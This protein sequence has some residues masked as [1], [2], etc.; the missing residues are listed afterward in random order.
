MSFALELANPRAGWLDVTVA[1]GPRIAFSASHVLN[2]PLRELAEL[3]LF[4]A[5]RDRGRCAV[6]FWLE[7]EGHELA[8]DRDDTLRLTWR[9]ADRARPD[10]VEPRLV[11]ARVVDAPRAIASE[12]L[13]AL[14]DVQP[15]LPV[16]GN[17]GIWSH[18][19]PVA[20]VAR[21]ADALRR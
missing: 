20:Q 9:S 6:R 15:H 12:I 3:A 19:F 21:L 5:S 1:L 14:R 4:I 18:P 13:R 10:L 2:D 16:D 11:H 17:S 7:P 8:A